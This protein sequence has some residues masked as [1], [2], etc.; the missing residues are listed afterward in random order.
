MYTQNTPTDVE[1]MRAWMKNGMA[2]QSQF[3]KAANLS[4]DYADYLTFGPGVY[5]FP[6]T[7]EGKGPGS[8]A[9]WQNDL[10]VS[11]NGT[12]RTLVLL[13]LVLVLLL[14]LPLPLPP[15]PLLLLLL[16]LLH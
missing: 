8:A 13:V 15:L 1:R 12:A 4:S 6:G 3:I 16:L 7:F 5:D 14:P 11:L 9:M 10:T 2:T